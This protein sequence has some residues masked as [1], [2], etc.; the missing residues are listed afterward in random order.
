M[1]HVYWLTRH[2]AGLA[3]ITL[4]LAGCTQVADD[5]EGKATAVRS[6]SPTASIPATGDPE[7]TV[8]RPEWIDAETL[9]IEAPSVRGSAEMGPFASQAGRI[10]VYVKCYGEGS[11]TVEIVDSAKFTQQCLIDKHDP[12]TRNQIQVAN[13]DEVIIRGTAE[14]SDLWA[15]AVTEGEPAS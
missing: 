9:L 11:L 7:P 12:G 13:P 2:I 3:A 15:I 4:A 1:G 5:P 8:L 10:A 14:S 6:P